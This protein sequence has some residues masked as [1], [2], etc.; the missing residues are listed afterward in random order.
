MNRQE[1]VFTPFTRSKRY[2]PKGIAGTSLIPEPSL[3]EP[4]PL[5][6]ISSYAFLDTVGTVPYY[7]PIKDSWRAREEGEQR[8]KRFFLPSPGL[9]PFLPPRSRILDYSHMGPPAAYTSGVVSLPLHSKAKWRSRPFRGSDTA[10]SDFVGYRNFVSFDRGT[11]RSLPEESV[12]VLRLDLDTAIFYFE[13]TIP[14]DVYLARCNDHQYALTHFI[15][16]KNRVSVRPHGLLPGLTNNHDRSVSEAVLPMFVTAS[17]YLP[18]Q[19]SLYAAAFHLVSLKF[20]FLLNNNPELVYP[21]FAPQK[22]KVH[23]SL[24]LKHLWDISHGVLTHYNTSKL[25]KHFTSLRPRVLSLQQAN[26]MK[27]YGHTVSKERLVPESF[28]RNLDKLQQ[29]KLN[30]GL[31]ISVNKN[32]VDSSINEM[33]E[34]HNTI[35]R[36]RSQIL[37][38]EEEI[39][40]AKAVIARYSPLWDTTRKNYEQLNKRKQEIISSI[41]EASLSDINDLFTENTIFPMQIVLR[42]L[43]GDR[44]QKINTAG[45]SGE[46]LASEVITIDLRNNT[47]RLFQIGRRGTWEVSTLRADSKLT[48][49]IGSPEWDMPFVEFEHRTP[50]KIKVYHYEEH[51]YS[52]LC[53]PV[54]FFARLERDE[55]LDFYDTE[56]YLTELRLPGFQTIRAPVNGSIKIHPHSDALMPDRTAKICLGELA[57]LLI[58]ALVNKELDT[59]IHGYLSWTKRA[60]LEDGWGVSANYFPRIEE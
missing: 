3:R 58:R 44:I 60:R 59:L 29:V 53:G 1:E 52:I 33:T 13:E 35:S 15:Y 14:R 8:L 49:A 7:T 19:N 17:N 10:A 18:D 40:N 2:Y 39:E 34:N 45:L 26:R 6:P 4:L 47:T 30:Y 11:V 57:P 31:K 24:R 54:G 28:R 16:L 55:N 56:A 42:K 38:L 12:H 9:G 50:I 27:R 23:E 48:E 32:K 43:T 46:L 20:T 22:E 36:L 25:E 5:H 41:S 21:V 37:E 51:Q